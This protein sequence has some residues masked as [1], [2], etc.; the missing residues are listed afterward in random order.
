MRLRRK[1]P[2]DEFKGFLDHGT[3][4]TGELRFSGTLRLDGNV[5]GSIATDDL[6][7]IGERA[8]VHADIKAGEVQIFGS[9]F[10][11]V[12]SER[13]VEVYPTGRLRGDVRTP[14]LIIDEGG[15]FEGRSHGTGEQVS[16]ERPESAGTSS[17][18]P[19]NATPRTT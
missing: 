11:N 4:L 18:M 19:D 17:F 12:E 10:G 9:V 13:K 8:T 15:T 16:P 2:S 1:S 6:L 5:H 7:I 3:S 14:Q